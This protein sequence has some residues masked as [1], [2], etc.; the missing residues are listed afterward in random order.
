VELWERALIR[1]AEEQGLVVWRVRDDGPPRHLH[2]F[3][4]G[5]PLCGNAVRSTSKFKPCS[6]ERFSAGPLCRYCSERAPHHKPGVLSSHIRT[7]PVTTCGTRVKQ[8]R[9]QRGW[10]QATLAKWSA[11]PQSVISSVERDWGHVGPKRLK[12]LAAALEVDPEI[13][14]R[15]S[16]SGAGDHGGGDP[17]DDQAAEPQTGRDEAEFAL[18]LVGRCD[19]ESP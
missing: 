18:P 12:R 8:L 17:Q 2:A 11:I 15:T 4:L 1:R 19:N 13:L 16:S 10:S 9:K 14:L 5:V 6:P 7:R 3:V